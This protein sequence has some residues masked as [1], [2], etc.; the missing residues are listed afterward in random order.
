[1][2]LGAGL[3]SGPFSRLSCPSSI[4]NA[5]MH[6]RSHATLISTEFIVAVFVSV[7]CRLNSMRYMLVFWQGGSRSCFIQQLCPSCS[8]KAF[9][10]PCCWYIR[11]N[12]NLCNVVKS[13]AW[14]VWWILVSFIIELNWTMKS[15]TFVVY[16]Q[17]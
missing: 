12:S 5:A 15:R 8:P 9:L 16:T 7:V 13:L 1:M 4:T 2:V 10:H 6:Q 17:S 14:Y 3:N 11:Q